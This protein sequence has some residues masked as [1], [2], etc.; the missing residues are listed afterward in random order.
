[1]Y[2]EVYLV[3]SNGLEIHI[4]GQPGR[5]DYG[6]LIKPPLIVAA[7]V[8][9][10][11]ARG[12]DSSV[13]P[14]DVGGDVYWDTRANVSWWVNGVAI[15]LY[16]PMLSMEQLLEITQSMPDPVW[17]YRK[18]EVGG[19]V[20]GLDEGDR[21]T[22][23]VTSPEGQALISIRVSN[24]AWH[25][26]NLRM[27]EGG[28]HLVAEA[29]PG[30]IGIPMD[31]ISF[32]VPEPGIVWR[33]SRLDFEFVRPGNAVE[34]FGLAIC[35]AS[36]PMLEA[37]EPQTAAPQ[38][39][40]EPPSVC[41]LVAKPFATCIKLASTK[42]VIASELRGSIAGPQGL[43]A[44]IRVV[45]LPRVEEECYYPSPECPF[46]SEPE[47]VD[48][49]PEAASDGL[50]LEIPISAEFW[51][52]KDPELGGRRLLIALHARGYRI[53][54]AGY[55]VAVLGGKAPMRVLGLDFNLVRE[56]TD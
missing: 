45:E 52:Y 17:D 20:S 29:P 43:Q 8:K 3:F 26:D 39:P 12:K 36:D 16:H 21:G 37:S 2:R 14:L 47:P 23:F 6:S 35:G 15:R 50:H 40:P 11:S 33:Y 55:I 25:L 54:P 46:Q 38:P 13:R 53:D 30:Y 24:G 18:S 19:T 56:P 1:M 41:S 34:R 7:T 42:P 27:P 44:T 22:L 51:G 31:F 28:Y 48:E 4:G 5:I 9:G 32:S 10:V 49:L